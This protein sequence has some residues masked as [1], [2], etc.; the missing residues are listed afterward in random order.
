MAILLYNVYQMVLFPSN[1]FF[2]HLNCEVFLA[3]NQKNF[4]VGK[5]VRKKQYFEKTL[6]SFKKAFLPRNWKAE[7]MLVVA[8]RLVSILL[9]FVF[10]MR[11]F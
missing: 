8:R 6:S 4:K 7:F 11:L 9:L 1:V 10:K 3:R 5:M 2:H